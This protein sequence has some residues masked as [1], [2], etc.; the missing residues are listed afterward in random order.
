M[1]RL[2]ALALMLPLLMGAD[3]QCTPDKPSSK[4][5]T[6]QV[7]S[8]VGS[9]DC[10]CP[11]VNL[12]SKDFQKVENLLQVKWGF[13]LPDG[14]VAVKTEALAQTPWTKTEFGP[15]EG[16]LAMELY[17][18][19]IDKKSTLVCVLEEGNINLGVFVG[20]G[21]GKCSGSSDID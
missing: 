13:T 20:S 7:Y 21:N 1:K 14:R 12:N 18:E 10:R 9:G 5:Y 3:K 2:L 19:A 6:W 8:W 17:A 15:K 11:S 16:A 4:A